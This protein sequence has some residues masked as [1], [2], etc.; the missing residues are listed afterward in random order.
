VITDEDLG[1]WLAGRSHLYLLLP[2]WTLWKRSTRENSLAEGTSQV[3]HIKDEIRAFVDS[4][5]L[6]DCLR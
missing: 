4:V 5:E 1:Q 6:Q 2:Y 3:E